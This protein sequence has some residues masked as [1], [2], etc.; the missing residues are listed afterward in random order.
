MEQTPLR[1]VFIY[2][3]S[4]LFS[5]LYHKLTGKSI[6]ILKEV[7]D[8][9]QKEQFFQT[10]HTELIRGGLPK[11]SADRQIQNMIR[12]L[13]AEDIREIEQIENPE[14]IS[15]LAHGILM[16]R[17]RKK[18]PPGLSAQAQEIPMQA[19]DSDL[20]IYKKEDFARSASTSAS[21]DEPLDYD[22]YIRDDGP[23]DTPTP[24]E[25]GK[26]IFWLIFACTLPLSLAL[27]IL[28]LG[29]FAGAFLALCAL[30][31]LLVGAMIGGVAAGSAVS[32]IGII[33]GITQLLTASSSAP[34]LYEIGLGVSVAGVVMIGGILL[35]NFAIRL[36]PLLIR[37]LGILFQF[38]T[39]QLKNLFHKAKEACYRL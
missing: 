36:I 29:V 4:A 34:G 5:L 23:D 8:S 16:F 24:T 39:G 10:L 3:R 15:E 28:Y 27:L 20:K 25:R 13:T 22:D 30:I 14:E 21:H 19:D 12:S 38:C 32:L 2:S 9:V 1:C 18:S 37:Y 35:Y 31:V 33:Y 7:V 26:R 17:Q 11:A 6:L